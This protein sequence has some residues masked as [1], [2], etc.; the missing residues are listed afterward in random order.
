MSK[1]IIISGRERRLNPLLSSTMSLL[2]TG[3]GEI[4]SGSPLRG[5]TLSLLR[6][7]SLLVK[8]S[9]LTEVFIALLFF[10]FITFFSPLYALFLSMQKKKIVISALSSVRFTVLF[11][12]FNSAITIISAAVFFSFFSVIRVGQNYPPIIEPGDFALIKKS[13]NPVYKSGEMIVLK[14][15]NLNLARIIG[16]PGEIISSEKGRFSVDRS[17]LPLSIFTEEELNKFSL[18]DYD[19]ISET[20]G[21]FKYPVIQNKSNYKLNISL[22][23]GRYFAVPD[24]RNDLAG[25]AAV[26]TSNIYGRLEGLL[27]SSKRVK[28]LIKPFRRAE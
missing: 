11:I 21:E 15:E 6:S 10:A 5:I 7:A 22:K 13:E 25:Y 9:Y 28:L 23:D 19:V 2:F 17:E 1:R 26:K 14:D 4:Y 8:S 12:T 18:T 3:T 27:F 20:Q 16:I 24:D